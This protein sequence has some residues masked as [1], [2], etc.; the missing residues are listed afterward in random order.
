WHI[1]GLNGECASVG[2][3]GAGSPQESWLKADLAAHPAAC[4][5]ALWHEPRFSSD[6]IGNDTTYD[7]FWQDLY[8]AGADVVLNGHSHE[9]ERFAPQDPN[10]NSDPTR[11]LVEMI[12][13][14][15]G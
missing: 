6:T 1:I 3:C 15:G 7:A 10:A 14:T 11:G 9:Y 13:G 8:A 2:G 5:M 4:T 12:V